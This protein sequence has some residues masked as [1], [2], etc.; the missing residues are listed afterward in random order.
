MLRGSSFGIYLLKRALLMVVVVWIASTA[1]FF[2]PRLT[3]LGAL[4]QRIKAA[5]QP[6]ARVT[7]L[8]REA[9][10]RYRERFGFSRP[11]WSQY[12][13]HLWSLARFDLGYSMAF[14]PVT[15]SDILRQ[16]LPW[17]LGLLTV[18]TA[19]AFVAGSLLGAFVGWSGGG[20]WAGLAALPFMAISAVPY[21][22]LALGLIFVF[23]FRLDW[24]PLGGAYGI[25]MFPEKSWA[26]VGTVV[27]HSVLPALSIM[28]VSI[29]F[30]ALSMRGM[31]VTVLAEDY[32]TM[33][34]AKGLRRVRVFAR[35]ALRNAL[36]PQATGLALSLGTLFT[37]V[38]LVEIV[39]R[40]PGVGD[41]LHRAIRRGDYFVVSG[42][43]YVTILAIA[44]ATFLMDVTYPL[45][46]PRIRRRP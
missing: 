45:L 8:Q 33:A 23:A 4:E 1:I 14:Y 28:L 18:T 42:I 12:A 26:F 35:Y 31:I 39:F 36:L 34:E 37:G 25:G 15:V 3:G 17:T 20:R 6:G 30:W 29:G 41:V 2:L 7:E 43:T 22:L 9:A 40:Y 27:H 5:E 13:R 24:F 16:S 21:Y 19:L 46:D 11:I 38:V 44:T 10:Q 32:M